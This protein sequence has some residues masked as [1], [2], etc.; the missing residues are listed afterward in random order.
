MK[1]ARKILKRLCKE[2]IPVDDYL[3]KHSW[4]ISWVN[5][6][7]KNGM[8][9]IGISITKS[10]WLDEVLEEFEGYYSR[11][12]HGDPYDFLCDNGGP[13]VKVSVKYKKYGSDI[14]E[15]TE[16][17][18][19]S[20]KEWVGLDDVDRYLIDSIRMVEKHKDEIETL[21]GRIK[22]LEYFIEKI[23]EEGLSEFQKS[24]L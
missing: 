3:R 15:V 22:D 14:S 16:R 7:S 11:N 21:E 5:Q 18:L 2:I 6:D 10:D 8:I 4:A 9:G 24:L 19:N 23:R 1:P 17:L 20:A 12:R 13:D